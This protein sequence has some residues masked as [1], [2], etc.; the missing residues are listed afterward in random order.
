MTTPTA[1]PAAG[2][3]PVRWPWARLALASLCQALLTT[4]V[5]LALWAAVP[6]LL[7]WQ[8]TT[9]SSGSMMPRLRIGDVAVAKPVTTMPAL[10]QVLLFRDPD[11]ADRLRLHRLVRIDDQ[12][13][14]VTRGDA[15]DGEDSS[16]IPLAD[17]QGV[18]VL[19]VP[20]VALPVV[21]LREG[22]WLWVGLTVVGLVLVA[23]GAR[24]GRRLPPDP[25]G[26]GHRD[27]GRPDD[28][29]AGDASGR[30]EDERA[31][32]PGRERP[33]RL[34]L[35]R[36][37]TALVAVLALLGASGLV[38][39]GPVWASY[40]DTT[41][42]PAGSLRS[43]TYYRCSNAV[44]AQ[45]PLL[46]LQ[47][48]ETS[49]GTADDSSVNGRDGTYVGGYSRG[50]A[51]SDPCATDSTIAVTLEDG[52]Y[53][54]AGA[55]PVAAPNTFTV[56]TWFKTSTGSG[57]RIIGFGSARSGSSGD[58]DRHVYLTDA[59]RLVFGLQTGPGNQR[60]T[61]STAARY[62]DGRWHLVTATLST[63]GMRL[64][65]DDVPAVTLTS[66]KAGVSYNGYWRIGYDELK[67]W[68]GRP[69]SDSFR[70]TVKQV[71]VYPTALTDQAVADIYA[72]SRP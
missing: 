42:N 25:E 52:G 13:W 31:A 9:V 36:S 5:C 62:D 24:V 29:G 22:R 43:A 38:A 23:L 3:P 58:A 69:S 10:N 59:G 50:G 6:A 51:G 72:A 61:L 53:I 34:G 12:G 7:G 54:V 19:R 71:A 20:S 70:G 48:A 56:Q 8:P 44:L 67:N 55:S 1:A 17:V 30:D 2:S 27:D 33:R 66:V 21:W 68:T 32:L 11:H 65:V 64:L 40:S 26:V 45:N 15:N 35:V 4:L 39:A 14:M 46:Y 37:A 49:G 60:Q 63:A 16:A 18:A 28:E 47:L 57:G 41:T